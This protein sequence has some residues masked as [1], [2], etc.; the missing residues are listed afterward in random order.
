[1]NDISCNNCGGSFTPN[2]GCQ[3]QCQECRALR[4]GQHWA[5]FNRARRLTKMRDPKNEAAEA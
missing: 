2:N 4:E 3:R 5:A 1:M